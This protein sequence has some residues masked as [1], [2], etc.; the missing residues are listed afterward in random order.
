MDSAE[1][2]YLIDIHCHL[3][4]GLDDG[5]ATMDEAI[6]IARCAVDDGVT[7]AIVTPH[8]H[9]GRWPN[10]RDTI[11]VELTRFRVALAETGVMLKLGMAAEVRLDAEI[12]PML[13][14]DR[15]PFLGLWQQ[16]RVLLLELPHGHFIPG[17]ENLVA[18][19]VNSGVLPMIAHPERNKALMRKPEILR[20]LSEMGCLFQITAGSL[21]G[22]FGPFAR[23]VACALVRNGQATVLASDAHCLGHRP[24]NL[25]AGYREAIALVGEEEAFKLVHTN[26]YVLFHSNTSTTGG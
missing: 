25:A 16:K 4:P 18:W 14:D 11:A 23:D 2:E 15:L 3:L 19:M 7:H 13:D 24:P 5:P 9:I 26:P 1:Y 21:I 6:A 12:I 20:L 8:I 10:D 17:T 22:Q